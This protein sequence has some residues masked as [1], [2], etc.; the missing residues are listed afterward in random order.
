[1]CLGVCLLS[2]W[3]GDERRERGDAPLGPV[4]AEGTEGQGLPSGCV[5]RDHS[6]T[7]EDLWATEL[8][9]PDH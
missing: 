2:G 7:M 9:G 4:L 6:P 3:G 1:M 8:F 5:P